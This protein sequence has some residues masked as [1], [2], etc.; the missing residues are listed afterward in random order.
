MARAKHDPRSLTQWLAGVAEPNRLAIIKLLATGAM[1]VTAL[2]KA[3][4]TEPVNISHHLKLMK[5]VGLLAAERDG[6]FIR[7]SL[8]GA[9][10]MVGFLEL[11]HESGAKVTLPLD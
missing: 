9:K 10:A 4:R 1:T 3:L 8:V 6:R 2:A 11:T 5:N 7:Y